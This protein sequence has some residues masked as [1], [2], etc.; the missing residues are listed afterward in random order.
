MRFVLQLIAKHWSKISV[1]SLIVIT[2]L[3]LIP[4]PESAEFPVSDKFQ[5][6]F[7]YGVLIFPVALRQPKYWLLVACFFIAWSGMIE[8]VQPY[9][10]RH[11]EWLDLL[12]NFGGILLGAIL[13]IVTQ[14]VLLK[15]LSN[16]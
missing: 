16:K 3:S 6:F 9:L 11:G 7:A 10:N 1:F 13:G 2:T 4:L 5:H 8:L 15:P 12:A 14:A